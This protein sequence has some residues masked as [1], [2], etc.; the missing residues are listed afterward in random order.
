M[1]LV[2][3][4]LTQKFVDVKTKEG[5]HVNCAVGRLSDLHLMTRGTFFLGQRGIIVDIKHESLKRAF[6][7]SQRTK[8]QRKQK[9]VHHE[10]ENG[11]SDREER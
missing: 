1:P 10:E 5:H 6:N 2:G 7:S 4:I 3:H 9:H 8:E 11:Y